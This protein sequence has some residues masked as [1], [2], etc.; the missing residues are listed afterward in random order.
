MG[1][2]CTGRPPVS[3]S[4]KQE[5]ELTGDEPTHFLILIL[6]LI[7]EDREERVGSP[8]EIVSLILKLC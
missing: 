8:L 5:E 3:D 6:I 7:R 2:P 4:C 1:G